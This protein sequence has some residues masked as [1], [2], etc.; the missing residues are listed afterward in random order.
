M[1]NMTRE[2]RFVR[3]YMLDRWT[4]DHLRDNVANALAK[5]TFNGALMAIRFAFRDLLRGVW[6]ELKKTVTRFAV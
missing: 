2:A 4:P 3:R 6:R 1:S 5:E